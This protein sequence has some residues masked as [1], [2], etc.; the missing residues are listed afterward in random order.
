MLVLMLLAATAVVLTPVTS[1]DTR[2]PLRSGSGNGYSVSDGSG[3]G[4]GS[5]GASDNVTSGTPTTTMAEA[6]V[7]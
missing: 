7:T 2:A 6:A 4:E 3:D 1:P 5:R